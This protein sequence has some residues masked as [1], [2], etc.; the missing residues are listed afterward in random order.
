MIPRGASL[1]VIEDTA[2]HSIDFTGALIVQ[3]KQR[4][5]QARAPLMIKVESFVR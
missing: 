2:C 1:F 5:S 4:E 3:A